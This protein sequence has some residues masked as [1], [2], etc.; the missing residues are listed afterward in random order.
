MPAGRRQPWVGH[1]HRTRVHLWHLVSGTQ[2][3]GSQK[4]PAYLPRGRGSYGLHTLCVHI[5]VAPTSTTPTVGQALK[6]VKCRASSKVQLCHV[7]DAY[8]NGRGQVL[9]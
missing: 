3:L 5:Y 8:L 1:C 2:V 6:I 7:V 4:D 9:G